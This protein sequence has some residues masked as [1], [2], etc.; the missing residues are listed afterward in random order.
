MI[1]VAAESTTAVWIKAGSWDGMRYHAGSHVLRH[2]HG[3]PSGR[4]R[5]AL[6]LR[7]VRSVYPDAVREHYSGGVLRFRW[8]VDGKGTGEAYNAAATRGPVTFR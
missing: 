1:T 2:P 4:A 5:T 7:A 8:D 6:L 3:R